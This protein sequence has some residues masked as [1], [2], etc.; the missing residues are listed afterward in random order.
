MLPA[1]QAID[2][3][4]FPP[5]APP[6]LAEG[7]LP[8]QEVETISA[9]TSMEWPPPNIANVGSPTTTIA[10]ATGRSILCG[11]QRTADE[12][13]LAR[14]VDAY[15]TREDA[16]SEAVWAISSFIKRTQFIGRSE[17]L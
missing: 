11:D 1:S 14:R 2:L 5:L 13:S 10:T 12:A 3:G 16:V 15:L 6:W 9:S 7:R 17:G 8:L 4:F